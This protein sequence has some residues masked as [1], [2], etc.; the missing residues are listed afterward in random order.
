MLFCSFQLHFKNTCV[1]SDPS[2]A[3]FMLFFNETVIF[4]FLA[5]MFYM[6]SMLVLQNTLRVH[7]FDAEHSGENIADQERAPDDVLMTFFYCKLIEFK[8]TALI[9]LLSKLS[10]FLPFNFLEKSVASLNLPR[11]TKEY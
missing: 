7:V 11:A 8:K 3:Q 10:R 2:G 6:I 1:L 9:K 5:K 4:N